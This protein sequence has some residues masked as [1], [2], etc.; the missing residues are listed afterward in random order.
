MGTC[1]ER[2]SII[3]NKV[4]TAIRL[5]LVLMRSNEKASKYGH[6]QLLIFYNFNSQTWEVDRS[7]PHN[8]V[9]IMHRQSHPYIIF[10][11]S[12]IGPR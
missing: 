2:H 10:H 12:L 7:F 9:K 6:M 5:M 3:P 8:N 11:Y 4:L 1:F